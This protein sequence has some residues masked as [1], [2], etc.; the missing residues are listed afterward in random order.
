MGWI[1]GPLLF[2]SMGPLVVLSV[3]EKRRVEPTNGCTVSS[4]ISQEAA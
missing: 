2:Q 1:S 3:H 4:D